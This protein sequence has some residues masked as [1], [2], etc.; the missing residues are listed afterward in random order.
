M[1]H[2]RAVPSWADVEAQADALD[3][4]CPYCDVDAGER[5]VSLRTGEQLHGGVSHWQRL[6]AA[7]EFAGLSKE[8]SSTP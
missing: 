1:S 3:C 5:C 2:L 7:R 8:S 4:Q 6:R